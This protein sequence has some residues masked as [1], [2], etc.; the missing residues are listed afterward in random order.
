MTCEREQK[1]VVCRRYSFV[2]RL[3][4]GVCV[5]FLSFC[6]LSALLLSSSRLDP[7]LSFSPSRSFLKKLDVDYLVLDE[8]HCIKNFESK[9]YTYLNQLKVLICICPTAV[10]LLCYAVLY[11]MS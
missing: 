9:R 11:F 5:G 7:L 8:A 10:V 2:Y 6:R 4:R 1:T 3:S